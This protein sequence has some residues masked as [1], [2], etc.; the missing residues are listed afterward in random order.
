MRQ[1][2]FG[3]LYKLRQK[4]TKLLHQWLGQFNPIGELTFELVSFF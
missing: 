1:N 2:D 4:V 3:R